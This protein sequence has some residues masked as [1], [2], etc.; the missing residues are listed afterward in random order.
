MTKYEPSY[1]SEL[2][3]IIMAAAQ[4][5]IVTRTIV[6]GVVGFVFGYAAGMANGSSILF[7]TVLGAIG[8]GLGWVTAQNQVLIMRAQAQLLLT[9]LQIEMNTRS[10]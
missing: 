2:A 7:A 8:A 4:R 10:R 5:I 3:T 1:V 9:Q 6:F